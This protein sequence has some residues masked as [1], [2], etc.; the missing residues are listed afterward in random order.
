MPCPYANALGIPG[1]GIHAARFLGMALNDWISTIIGAVLI[2]LIFQTNVFFSFLGLFVGGEI[3]H[4][5][6]GVKTA[7]LK[8]IGLEPICV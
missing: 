4:Y 2:S 3:L 1:Q 8:G 7:F 5:V 6:F